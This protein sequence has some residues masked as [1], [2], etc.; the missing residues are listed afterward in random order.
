MAEPDQSA[1]FRPVELGGQEF[2][3]SG[4]KEEPEQT[5]PQNDGPEFTN[6]Q[7][8]LKKFFAARPGAYEQATEDLTNQLLTKE[9]E[10][11]KCTWLLAEV[12]HWNNEKERIILMTEKSLYICK[13]DFIMLSCQQ[14]QKVPLN[15][16]DKICHGPFTFPPR[17]LEKRE[18]DG[19][20]IHWDKLREVT[21][22]SRWNP[23]SEDLP[24][25][26]FTDHPLK[27]CS[28]KFSELCQ[29][30]SLADRLVQAVQEAHRETPVPGRANG[31][32]FLKQPNLIETY[33]G[34]TS[35]IANRNKLGYSLARGSVG[36]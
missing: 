20:R 22:F 32:L 23:L 30:S 31:V 11:V 36:F 2:P 6:N 29:I 14:I 10:V 1:E 21:F 13:Y 25:T 12:D 24:Y 27:N 5:H 15:Y 7:H 8:L 26:T 4:V 34:I 18:G 19:L 33:V 3:P 35:F 17:S 16:I 9:K 28:L